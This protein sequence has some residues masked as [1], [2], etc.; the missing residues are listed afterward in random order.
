VDRR[1][2][3]GIGG[4]CRARREWAEGRRH[5]D[6][7]LATARALNDRPAEARALREIGLLLRD[8]GDLD[9]S[10]QALD[11][12]QEIFAGLGD[13]LWTARVLASKAVLEELR[14]GDPEPLARQ[15]A[16]ICRQRGIA[17]DKVTSALRGSGE[18]AV[19]RRQR[20]H[21]V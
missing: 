12:S 16:V 1:T 21:A 9:G 18:G 8:Y 11:A 19:G 17:E 2:H 4:L 7:A 13:E 14:G 6:A 5:L 3:A 15:A 20:F 10:G